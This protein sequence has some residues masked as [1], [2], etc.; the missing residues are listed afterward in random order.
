MSLA[1]IQLHKVKESD[2]E[3]VYDV[4]SPDFSPSQQWEVVAH[5]A[6]KK[7]SFEYDFVP[8]N[9]WIGQKIVPPHVYELGH[10]EMEQQLVGEFANHGY[11]AWTGRIAAQLRRMREQYAYPDSAP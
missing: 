10:D 9:A 3:V 11:G 2:V 1:H 5:I 4:L 7:S 8:C 6:I